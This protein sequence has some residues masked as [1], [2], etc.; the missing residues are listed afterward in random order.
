[1]NPRIITACSVLIMS[2]ST[3]AA[4]LSLRWK[5]QPGVDKISLSPSETAEIEVIFESFAAGGENVSAIFFSMEAGPVQ[6]LANFAALPGWSAGGAIDLPF[7]LSQF[8]VASNMPNTP[9]DIQESE[10]FSIVV[11]SFVIRYDDFTSQPGTE[12]EV[13][14]DGPGGLGEPFGLNN[15][16]VKSDGSFF[17]FTANSLLPALSGYFTF[18]KGS[19]GIVVM[20]DIL[21]RDPL[22]I[23]KAIPEPMSLALLGIAGMALIFHRRMGSDRCSRRFAGDR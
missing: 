3:H 4:V 9:T 2:A 16:I 23:T 14:F 1:M 11:G 12:F 8:A 13:A 5:D 21:P 6:H 18:G 17:V 15:Q 10:P 19:P 22:I 20:M 7:G